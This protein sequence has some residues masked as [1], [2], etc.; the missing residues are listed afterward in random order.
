MKDVVDG[1]EL[2]ND[3]I[4][5]LPRSLCLH[6][7]SYLDVVSLCRCCQ[8]SKAWKDVADDVS[9]WKALCNKPEWATS[10]P[11]RLFAFIDKKANSTILDWKAAFAERYRI[12]NNWLTGRCHVRTFEGHTQGVS[13]VQFDETRI[14][15]GSSD[16]T[17]KV[18]N[19]RT[20][21][22][23]AVQTLVG[24]SGTVRCLYLCANQLVSGS[25]DCTIKIWD[26]SDS[27]TWS[28]I[29]CRATLQG[30]TDAVRC[31]SVHDSRLV[32]GSYD[33]TLKVWDMATRECVQTLVGHDAAVL[34]VQQNESTVV[35]GSCDKTIKIW[36][37]GRCI[38]TLI[39]H[40]DAVTCLQLDYK[41]IIS[42]SV[43]CTIKFWE[44]DVC[45]KT[46]DW[47]AS[48]GHTGVVR[49]IQTD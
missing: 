6:I 15:S 45:A 4:Q 35:S 7:F 2:G 22:H 16:K 33:K 28:S 48:E 34:C 18:W 42:G 25:T 49:C 27:L 5:W 38:G 47:M 44:N 40:A 11:D 30:H 46:I 24:H 20:N 23:L 36:R 31:V 32:S 3:F 43:D 17:I 29:A 8:A 9:L 19:M 12:R 37:E 1:L 41:R 10:S 21:S 13:C 26:L 39:G 14:V